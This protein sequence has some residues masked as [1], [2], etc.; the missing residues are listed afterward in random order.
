M[1]KKIL[2]A[3]SFL[4]GCILLGGCSAPNFP[5]LSSFV[6]QNADKYTM[7][8]AEL[9]SEGISSSDIDWVSGEINVEYHSEHTVTISETSNKSL[10][11]N[12]TMYYLLD[13]DTLRIKFAKSGKRVPSNLSKELTVYLPEGMELNEVAVDS[14]SADVNVSNLKTEDIKI[15]TTSGDITFEDVT[16]TG[17]AKFD[18]TSGDITAKLG[19]TLTIFS[20]DTTSGDMEFFLSAANT[21]KIDSTS[22]EIQ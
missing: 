21:V 5:A 8:N 20:A 17:Q 22:G 6:Y 14:V 10:N 3:T 16:L 15:D 2:C 18:T 9:S 11:D 12:T 7:G 4:I 19:G 1:N 13:G